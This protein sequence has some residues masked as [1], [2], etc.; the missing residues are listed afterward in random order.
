[1][2]TLS[3]QKDLP[4]LPVNAE[5]E[6]ARLEQEFGGRQHLVQA[7]TFAKQTKDVRYVLGLIADPEHSKMSL[8]EILRAGRILPGEL[9]AALASG[10]ELRSQLIAR[11]H[12]AQRIPAVVSEVMKQAAEYEDDCTECMG[13]GKCTP[14]PTES[15][16]NPGPEDCQTCRGTGRLRYPADGKCRDLALEMAGLVGGNSGPQ[17]N[18]SVTQTT[19]AAFLGGSYEGYERMQEAMDQILYGAGA[20]PPIAVDAEAEEIP[21]ES[22]PAPAS[23]PASQPKEPPP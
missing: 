3:R 19:N 10:G 23:A 8:A 22:E 18:V 11:Q 13:V 15:R 6:L 17:V 20:V 14:D 9:V 7:L 16:P 5:L 12:V 21:P 4:K 2:G 1:M